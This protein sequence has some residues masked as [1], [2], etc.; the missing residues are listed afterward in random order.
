MTP[1]IIL[2]V[3]MVPLVTVYLY[4][5]F[6]TGSDDGPSLEEVLEL[7]HEDDYQVR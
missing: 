2:L 7:D 3:C 1:G 5:L 4:T 6:F